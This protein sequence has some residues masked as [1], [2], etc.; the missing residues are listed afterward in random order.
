MENVK[1]LIVG[2]GFSGVTLANKIATELGQEVVIIDSKNHIGGN[3]YDYWDKNG[4]CVHQYGTHIFH[5]NLKN[6]WDYVSTFTQWYPYM[7]EVK[8][9][10]DGQL[11]PIPFNLNSIHQVFPKSIADV[12]ETKLIAKF[13]FNVKVPILELRKAGDKDLEFLADYV[14][15]K[16]FLHYTL[17]Q[18]GM[19]PED[20]DPAVTGR[21]PV[22]ISRDNRYFQ[23]IYQGI[24]L[25]GYTAV[26]EKMLDNPLIKVKLNTKWSDI[27]GKV[28]YDRLFFTGP[29][30]EFFEYEL[31]ELPYRSLKFDFLTYDKPYFQTN[32]V[33]NYPNNYNWT[34][35]GEY[36]YFLDNKSEKTVVSYEYPINFEQGKNDRY[37]PIVKQENQDLYN[38]YL[39]KAKALKNV[40]F[41]GRL[42]DY[43]YY[44]MDKAI[45]RALDLFEEVKK[46]G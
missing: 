36:K 33:V 40:Y 8:G 37:Y 15:E 35:I 1:N 39:E 20:L 16:I 17:K 11:V 32:S 23:D 27:K 5:T 44:D 43:K 25:N 21:V 31:G 12:L 26:I 42:G 24:P 4:I 3:C 7:H 30:D 22:Y 19:K 34:R 28:K 13:G 10:I 2:M 18:W 38:R 14:Y 29:I 46:N 9:Q 6:V 45:A 41:L